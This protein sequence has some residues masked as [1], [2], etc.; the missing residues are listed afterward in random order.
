MKARQEKKGVTKKK[1]GESLI[2]EKKKPRGSNQKTLEE[3]RKKRNLKGRS[4]GG[5]FSEKA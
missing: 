4:H 3:A 1:K 5:K 2:V